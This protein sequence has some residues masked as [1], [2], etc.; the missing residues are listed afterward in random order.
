MD[1][2][3]GSEL[4]CRQTTTHREYKMCTFTRVNV[5]R[6]INSYSKQKTKRLKHPIKIFK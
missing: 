4:Q 5:F 6:N 2:N 3:A 1:N